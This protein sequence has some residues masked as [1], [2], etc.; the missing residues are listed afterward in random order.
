[1]SMMMIQHP[2]VGFLRGSDIATL[3]IKYGATPNPCEYRV[4]SVVYIEEKKDSTDK[5]HQGVP[6]CECVSVLNFLPGRE[7]NLCCVLGHPP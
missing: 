2:K 7:I 5:E 6:R 1:M 4:Q 3:P